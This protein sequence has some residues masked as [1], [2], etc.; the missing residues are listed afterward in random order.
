MADVAASPFAIIE[1]AHWP[2]GL[3]AACG[4]VSCYGYT[5]VPIATCTS[6][7]YSLCALSIFKYLRALE[8]FAAAE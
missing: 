3:C 1:D 5:I 2:D 7:V 6:R 4:F 8:P